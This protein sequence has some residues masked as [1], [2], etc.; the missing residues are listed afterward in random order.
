MQHSPLAL[1]RINDNKLNAS[2]DE[3]CLFHVENERVYEGH[4]IAKQCN[5]CENEFTLPGLFQSL[6]LSPSKTNS[7][8]VPETIF[9]TINKTSAG[10]C[11]GGKVLHRFKISE[12]ANLVICDIAQQPLEDIFYRLNV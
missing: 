3:S 7:G 5:N 4:V 9:Y 1:R 12:I 11:S 2:S 10:G 8:P 6:H